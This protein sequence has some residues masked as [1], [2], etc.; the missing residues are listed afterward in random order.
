MSTPMN[1]AVELAHDLRSPLSAFT[2]L[3]QLME[4]GAAGPMTETQRHLLTVMHNAAIGMAQ[5]TTDILEAGRARIVRGREPTSAFEVHGVLR[6]VRRIVQ[7]LAEQSGLN[8]VVTDKAP[9]TW[10]GCPTAITRVLLNL[11]TNALKY[12]ERGT[13][14]YGARQTGPSRLQFFVRDTGGGFAKRPQP[15]ASEPDW[16]RASTGLG[17]A[18]SRQ[19]LTEMGSTLELESTPGVGCYAH[20]ELSSK[21]AAGTARRVLR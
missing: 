17:L 20:F 1:V 8:I 9:R 16:K 3:T 4:S 19:L 10:R 13:V 6:T 5:M 15:A 11:T 2:I 14:E 18:M 21:D 12:T 7:P